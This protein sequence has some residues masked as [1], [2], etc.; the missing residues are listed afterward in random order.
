[1]IGER[2]LGMMKRCRVA[3][4]VVTREWVREVRIEA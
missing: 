4:E 3:G 1:M 2:R